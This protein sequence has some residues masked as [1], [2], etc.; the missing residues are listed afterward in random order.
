MVELAKASTVDPPRL[1]RMG[2]VVSGHLI[3]RRLDSSNDRLVLVP[4]FFLAQRSVAINQIS[5][6][7]DERRLQGVY[8]GDQSLEWLE[9]FALKPRARVADD[10]EFEVRCSCR[11]GCEGDPNQQEDRLCA[12]QGKAQRPH[13]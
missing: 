2:V 7:H 11:A 6:V 10:D 8:F 13:I 12:V 4:L 3:I 1:F 9:A 5:E